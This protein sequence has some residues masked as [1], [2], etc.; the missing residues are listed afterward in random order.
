LLI[1][2]WQMLIGKQVVICQQNSSK[3]REH[4]S[5]VDYGIKEYTKGQI[6]ILCRQKELVELLE[7]NFREDHIHL[8][9]SIPPKYSVSS[10]MGFLNL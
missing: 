2:A 1:D 5:Y 7:L 8:V 4:Y 6:Y 3:K 9:M 10:V